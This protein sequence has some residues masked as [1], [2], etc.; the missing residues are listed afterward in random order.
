MKRQCLKPKFDAGPYEQ[1]FKEHHVVLKATIGFGK[2]LTIQKLEFVD[3][4]LKR[5]EEDGL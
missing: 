3:I 2:K 1:L 4:E 5:P